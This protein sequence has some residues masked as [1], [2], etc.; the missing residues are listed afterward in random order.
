M[1]RKLFIDFNAYFASCEQHLRPELRGRPVGITPVNTASG[2]CIAASYEAKKFGVKTGTRVG[3]A[4]RLCPDIVIVEARPAE[5]VRLH[6]ELVTLID[7]CMYVE[8]VCSI[9]EMRCLLTGRWQERERAIALARQIKTRLAGFS[10]ALRCSIGIGPND[11]LAKT[12]S[13]LQKPDGLVILEESDLPDAL[14]DLALEDLCGIGQGMAARLERSGVRTVGE[15]YELSRDRLRAVWGGVEGERMWFRLRG[16]EVPLPP[17]ERRCYGH[18]HV[19]PPDLRSEPKAGAV[20]S[21][22][23][24]KAA[25]R[26]RNGG[27]FCSALTVQVDLYDAPPWQAGLRFDPTQSS[28]RLLQHFRRLWTIRPPL[29]R[30][31]C[32]SV[33]LHELESTEQHTPSLWR[34]DEENRDHRIDRVVDALNRLHGQRT[35][36]RASSLEAA[37]SAPCRIAFTRIPDL[38]LEG[39][40]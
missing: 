8:Q 4:R 18:S 20:L 37:D 25:M 23:L 34:S 1:L 7:S 24:Q 26:L 29:R 21:R 11:W 3:E 28:R 6:H 36:F 14:S 12:A 30:P 27:Y 5:Y 16:H 19:L 39:E 32:V 17:T 9:D 2:C 40:E 31:F 15:L 13:E 35:V 22:L 10:T 38:D 33:S